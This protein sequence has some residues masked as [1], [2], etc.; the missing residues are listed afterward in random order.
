[1]QKGVHTL[2]S[3]QIGL[4]TG[5]ARLSLDDEKG[6]L[7]FNHVGEGYIMLQ[8]VTEYVSKSMCPTR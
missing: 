2:P 7:L 4:F 6:R 3:H 5:F 8:K 1:M